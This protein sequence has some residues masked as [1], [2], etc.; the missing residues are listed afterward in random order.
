M[1]LQKIIHR[2]VVTRSS[3]RLFKGGILG[4]IFIKQSLKSILF[5]V[6]DLM[7]LLIYN[8][9]VCG[10]RNSNI[11]LLQ[12]YLIKYK[13]I[14][15]VNKDYKEFRY[16]L[17]AYVVY[18]SNLTMK[19]FEKTNFFSPSPHT[20]R[21][22]WLLNQWLNSPRL[23]CRWIKSTSTTF[24]KSDTALQNNDWNINWFTY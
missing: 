18:E 14:D 20:F 1:A 2:V 8:E 4:S 19:L 5:K 21:R 15:L 9:K 11:M 22:P 24:S 6:Y 17:K 13:K 12:Y 7:A 3:F 16:V 23:S 10:N